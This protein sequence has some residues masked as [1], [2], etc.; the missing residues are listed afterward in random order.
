VKK[1]VLV[2][3]ADLQLALADQL[4]SLDE[5]GDFFFVQVEGHFVQSEDDM[6]LSARDKVVGYTPRVRVD[7]LLE[8]ADVRK[9][10]ESVRL[11]TDGVSGRGVFWVA[12]VLE[13]G[14]L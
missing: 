3:H 11:N 2:I 1:L 8:D 4:R 13:H 10:I 14:T 6:L 5:V 9:V 7:L 12:D